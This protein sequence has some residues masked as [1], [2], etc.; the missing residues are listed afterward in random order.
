[1]EI[2][3][4]EHAIFNTQSPGLNNL[5]LSIIIVQIWVSCG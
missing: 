4:A 5:Q 2:W 1:M 3:T